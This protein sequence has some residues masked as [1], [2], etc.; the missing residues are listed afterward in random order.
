MIFSS[1]FTEWKQINSFNS[2]LPDIILLILYILSLESIFIAKVS[3][4]CL[5]EILKV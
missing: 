3:I 2:H 5:I 4:T 1:E